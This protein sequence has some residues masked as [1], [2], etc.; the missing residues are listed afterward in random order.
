MSSLANLKDELEAVSYIATIVGIVIALFVFWSEK[1]KERRAREAEGYARA[2][3]RYIQYLTLCLDHPDANTFDPDITSTGVETKRLIMFSILI[4][5]FETA[6]LLLRSASHDIRDRQWKGWDNYIRMWAGQEDF[7]KTWTA[8][9]PDFD[10]E[11]QHYMN[12]LIDKY[13]SKPTVENLPNTPM[14]PTNFGGG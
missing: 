11:F 6:Y 7:A 10:S 4:N 3:D 5:V 2:N 9:G 1:R 13:Q 14:Q 12:G 8:I